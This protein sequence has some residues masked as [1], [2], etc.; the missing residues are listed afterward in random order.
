MLRWPI[1]LDPLYTCYYMM[2]LG[3]TESCPDRTSG[4]NNCGESYDQLMK[5]FLPHEL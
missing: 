4:W 5:L 3:R 2:L 1:I